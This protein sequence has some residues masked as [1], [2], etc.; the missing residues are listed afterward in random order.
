M[1]RIRLVTRGD[2]SGSCRAANAAVLE[3]YRR[4][5]MRN[6]S[7]QAAGPAFDE[8]A[9]AFKDE[10]GLCIGLHATITCEWNNVRWG[11]VLGAA[12][13]PTLVM[14]D[15]SFFKDTRPLAEKSPPASNDEIVAELAAQLARMRGAGLKV[16]YMDTHMGFDWLP[17]LDAHLAALAKAEGLVY[18]PAVSRLP[19]AQGEY[20]GPGERL[21]AQLD[22]A[23]A[24]GTYLIV[25][26]PSLD[27]DE[28]RAMTYG[29]RKPGD[30][31]RERDA[32]RRMYT[33][34]RVMAYCESHGVE[35]I[36]YTE[37][38]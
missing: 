18:K 22:A 1:S 11:P 35:L 6:A 38:G 2:D 17:G 27:D 21:I 29:D 14:P 34:A 16:S 20:A 24:G 26:H 3:A 32:D 5:I 9:R 10:P 28:M 23:P 13:T 19:K 37:I 31:A 15:G 8:A 4:G 25:T 30:V 33:D 12:K 7:V 36:R